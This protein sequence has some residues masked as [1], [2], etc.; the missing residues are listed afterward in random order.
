MEKNLDEI[1]SYIIRFLLGDENAGYASLVGY[2]SGGEA[3]SDFHVVIIPSGFFGKDIFGTEKSAPSLPLQNW[4]NIPLL[5]GKSKT[6]KAGGT[7]L[8]HADIIASTFFLIS[9]YE[10]TLYRSE[11]DQHGRFPGKKSLAFRAGFLQQPVVDEYGKA[12]RAKLR[13][14]GL[15]IKEPA[16]KF[17]KIYLT[18]D[19]DQLAHYRNLRGLGG[20]VSRFFK[21]PYQTLKA[22]ESYFGGIKNDPWF[23]FPW[24]FILADELKNAKPQAGVECIVFIKTGGGE[25]TTDKPLHQISNKDF[26]VLFRL[27]KQHGV[28]TGLHPSYHAG[29]NPEYIKYEKKV[30]DD[31]TSEHTK[32]TRNHF[33]SNREP[34]DLQALIDAGLSDDFTMTYA[35]IA[36]F[37]LGTCRSVKWINP[38]SLELTGL[39]LHPLTLMD[40]TLSDE[41]YMNLKADEAFS[42]SKKM[43]DLVR[44]HNGDLVLLWHNTSVEKHN[45][46]YHRDLYHWIINYLK[47]NM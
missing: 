4:E 22:V 17:N 36:G 47:M 20:A 14:T 41:R 46:Q 5:F 31:T 35:D 29:M 38:L 26:G 3:F 18:H 24:L 28:K 42:F 30:L 15:D 40:S 37:R 25:L 45:N 11:R 12:L 39:T 13:E 7:I 33:L 34:E 19:V 32:F 6:E 10:E 9:R 8:I 43:M 16:E 44:K 21:N 23:T 27:C 1:T 2:T